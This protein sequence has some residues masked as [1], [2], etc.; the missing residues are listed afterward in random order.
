MRTV[1]IKCRTHARSTKAMP[2]LRRSP[3]GSLANWVEPDSAG[4]MIRGG[5]VDDESRLDLA[6]LAQD[7]SGCIGWH[8]ARTRWFCWMR[9]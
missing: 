6:E 5:F 1:L 7:G 8:G 2:R 3:N 9:G 4:G